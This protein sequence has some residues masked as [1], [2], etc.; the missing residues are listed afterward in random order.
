MQGAES[1]FVPTA[2]KAEAKPWRG[3]AGTRRRHPDG[4][5]RTQPLDAARR[6][7]G[8]GTKLHRQKGKR[9]HGGGRM[10]KGE[11][12]ENAKQ[13]EGEMGPRVLT[14]L[15]V[16]ARSHSHSGWHTGYEMELGRGWR[17]VE[18]RGARDDGLE[19]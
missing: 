8:L 9:K 10:G 14:F 12:E 18:G 5:S 17:R 2:G 13:K 11:E 19:S 16:Q 1:R 7:H 4:A 6:A 15:A 3:V